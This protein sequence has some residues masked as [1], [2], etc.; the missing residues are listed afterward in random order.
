MKKKLLSVILSL[1][2]CIV[3]LPLVKP[4]ETEAGLFYKKVYVISKSQSTVYYY[5]GVL[6][7]GY[8]LTLMDED[9]DE[10]WLTVKPCPAHLLD[11][12]PY[13]TGPY[14]LY[15]VKKSTLNNG[16]YFLHCTR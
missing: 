5:N 3:V 4:T 15:K 9:W 7:Y 6:E 2:L 13:N 12:N 8:D 11:F 1:A 10:Y 16:T 14:T